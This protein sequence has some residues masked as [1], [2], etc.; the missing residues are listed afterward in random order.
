[1]HRAVRARSAGCGLVCL[2]LLSAGCQEQPTGGVRPAAAASA[3]ATVAQ[4]GAVPGLP[5]Y[6]GADLVSFETGSDR[7]GGFSRVYRATFTCDAPFEAVE[8]FYERMILDGGW[9]LVRTSVHQRLPDGARSRV[10]LT[11][12]KGS[13]LAVVQIGRENEAVAFAIERKDR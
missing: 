8:G 12:S 1:M 4:P 3:A 11:L 6:P 7:R 10:Q 2:V 5:C 9:R 13:S